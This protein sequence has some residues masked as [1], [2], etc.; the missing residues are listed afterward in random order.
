MKLSIA[1]FLRVPLFF[2]LATS[3]AAGSPVYQAPTEMRIVLLV[4]E[5]TDYLTQYCDKVG[6]TWVP[7]PPD[8]VNPVDFC[9]FFELCSCGFDKLDRCKYII[10]LPIR[11]HLSTGPS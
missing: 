1:L 8:Q 7:P 2:A 5:E 10:F 6:W 11:I 4:K 3:L 9:S